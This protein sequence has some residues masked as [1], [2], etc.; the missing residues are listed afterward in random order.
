MVIFEPA[1]R[2]LVNIGL[3]DVILPFA[4]AFT[5]LYAILEATKVLGEEKGKPKTKLNIITA[6]VMALLVVSSLYLTG[7]LSNIA[8]Y[9]ALALIFAI[10]AYVFANM[11]GFTEIKNKN[12]IIVSGLIIICL[13]AIIS[14]GIFEFVSTAIINSTILPSAI[15]ILSMFLIVWL[16]IH[17]AKSKAPAPT[18]KKEKKEGKK[19]LQK[20][21]RGE[22]KPMEGEEETVA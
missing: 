6:F 2:L 7:I 14:L 19:S 10:F 11:L 20:T 18:E 12:V 15:I 8:G 21:S 5:V 16:V 17:E 22:F 4:L 3:L 9:S 1:F 13:I